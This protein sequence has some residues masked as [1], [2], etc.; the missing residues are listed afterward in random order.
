MWC[1]M[2]IEHLLNLNRH[3]DLFSIRHT[4]LAYA[5][6]KKYSIVPFKPVPVNMVGLMGFVLP[7]VYD[8][9]L[10]VTSYYL[11]SHCE[12]TVISSVVTDCHPRCRHNTLRQCNPYDSI[13]GFNLLTMNYWHGCVFC[14]AN[15]AAYSFYK[16][17]SFKVWIIG[18][19]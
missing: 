6:P 3:K 5:L 9:N 19:A 8:N 18:Q 7:H 16:V 1:T 4:R 12:V 13:S 14:F 15:L 2:F 17:P 10:Y 11:C